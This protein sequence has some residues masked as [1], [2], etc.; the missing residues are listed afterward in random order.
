ML[1]VRVMDETELIRLAMSALGKR[2]SER[3]KRS[4]RLNAQRPRKRK[5]KRLARVG[6]HGSPSTPNNSPG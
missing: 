6:P 4:S 2:T 3:K 5:S 1:T